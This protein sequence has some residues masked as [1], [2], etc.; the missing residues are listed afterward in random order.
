MDVGQWITYALEWGV[1]R[2]YK[3]SDLY[4]C[5]LFEKRNSRHLFCIFSSWYFVCY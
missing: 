3:T 1:T 4:C 5:Y 2:F